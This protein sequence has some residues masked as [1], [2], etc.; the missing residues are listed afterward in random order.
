MEMRR[1][2]EA[3]C[4]GSRSVSNEKRFGNSPQR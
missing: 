4:D 2:G 1:I 3:G